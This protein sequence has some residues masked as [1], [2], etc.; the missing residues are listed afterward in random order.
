MENDRRIKAKKIEEWEM[1][2]SEVKKK[3][4]NKLTDAPCE[5]NINTVDININV[6]ESVSSENT[7]FVIVFVDDEVGIP[8]TLTKNR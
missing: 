3:K 1:K 4:L 7:H 6:E 8:S 5:I 2:K